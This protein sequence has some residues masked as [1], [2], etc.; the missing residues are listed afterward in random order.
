VL[1][2]SH[3]VLSDSK[4]SDNIIADIPHRIGWRPMWNKERFLQNIGDEIQAVVEL[5]KAK[6]SLIDS[7]FEV[8]GGQQGQS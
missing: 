5:G 3:E 2:P 4:F 1:H 7:L 6:S 8:A